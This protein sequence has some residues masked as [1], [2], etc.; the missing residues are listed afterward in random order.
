MNR[1]FEGAIFLLVAGVGLSCQSEAKDPVP[2]N[3]FSVPSLGLRYTPPAGMIDETSA[4][5]KDA[6][7]HAAE[8]TS[9]TTDLI[10][11]MSSNDA[12]TAPDWH[13]IWIFIYPR[14]QLSNLTDSA[15][16]A[17][18]NVSLAGPRSVAVGQPRGTVLSG[19]GFTV[20]EFE[21]REPPLIKHAKIFTTICKG[22][23]VSFVLVSNSEVQVR[24][25][26]ESLKTLDFSGR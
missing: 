4:A 12:D 21:Q 23:L 22:Q 20:S 14:V 25:M 11:D 1:S 2:G 8:H 10:L 19:L 3:V 26:E 13:Q 7:S 15:A 18:I 5:G 9:K 24:Q 16:Q 17:K 6:R